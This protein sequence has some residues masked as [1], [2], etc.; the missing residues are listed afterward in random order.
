[1]SNT[2]QLAKLD[3]DCEVVI[4]YLSG[5]LLDQGVRT[6]RSFDLQ[7]ACASYPDLT[8]SHHENMACDCQLVIL[9]AYGQ[10][11]L[12]KTCHAEHSEASCFSFEIF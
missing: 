9:L 6:V 3:L 7:S 1:M 5:Y 4:N 12:N 10:S 11:G 8:C 2:N